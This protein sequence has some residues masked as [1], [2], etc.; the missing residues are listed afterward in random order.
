MVK[1]LVTGSA[2]FIGRNLVKHLNELGYT[3]IEY[4]IATGQDI[5][6]YDQLRSHIYHCDEVYHLAAQAFVGPGEADPYRD[7]DIN[8]KGMLNILRCVEEFNIPMVYT[9]SGSVYGLTDSFPHAEDALIRPTANYG[10]SKR[11]AELALQKWVIMKDIDAKITRFSSVYGVDRGRQGPVNIFLEKALKGEPLTVFGDGSQ[12]RDLIYISDVLNGLMIVMHHG[13]PGEIYN[14][15]CGVE[16]KV[17]EVAEI[18]SKLTE[19]KITYV[20]GHKFSP[21][22]VK[23]SYFKIEKARMLGYKP[24]VSL[25][26]GIKR[27]YGELLQTSP[28]PPPLPEIPVKEGDS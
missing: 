8:G 10:C 11:Y 22:D 14:I 23:R 3:V 26:E 12:S 5:L 6:D 1:A 21:F 16:Y 19:A 18:I 4:D 24:E 9:S 2:G 15:G 25:E 17:R 7:L 13:T 27:I 28:T 20:K